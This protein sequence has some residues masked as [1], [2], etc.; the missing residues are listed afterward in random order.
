MFA[1]Q[2]QV[3]PRGRETRWVIRLGKSFY[4]AYLTRSTRRA[5]P[6][7]QAATPRSGSKTDRPWRGSSSHGY[8][9]WA[10]SDADGRL[11]F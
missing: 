3:C 4:G 9:Y 1:M 8:R 5:T 7:R 10:R 2:F 6:C 11:R